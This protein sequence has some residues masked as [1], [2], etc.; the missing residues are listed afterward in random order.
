MVPFSVAE[1]RAIQRDAEL[2]EA[3]A[4]WRRSTGSQHATDRRW[5]MAM[6]AA[7]RARSAL[8]RAEVQAAINRNRRRLAA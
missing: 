3:I 5:A 8:R 2:A 1:A 7:E 6:L 4:D